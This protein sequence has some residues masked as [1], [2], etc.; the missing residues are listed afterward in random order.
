MSDR[1]SGGRPE[2]GGRPPSPSGDAGG[3]RILG[4]DLLRS[5]SA[6]W[7]VLTHGDRLI[8]PAFPRYPRFGFFNAVDAFFVLSG[9]L[10]G[11][12][13][14]RDVAEGGRT[15]GWAVL[16]QFYARRWL[17]T[18]PAYW[19]A[20]FVCWVPGRLIAGL[21]PSPD[22]RYPF[23]LQNAWTP[24]PPFFPNAWSLCIE[25]WFY[26]LF[27]AAVLLF[28]SIFRLRSRAAF[29]A[30][31]GLFIVTAMIAR[32]LVDGS[33][34]VMGATQWRG[35]FLP[36]R[37][38][39]IA[40][41]AIAALVFEAWPAAWR[42]G[43]VVGPVVAVLLV[44]LVPRLIGDGMARRALGAAIGPF[45]KSLWLPLF[46]RIHSAPG[47]IARTVRRLSRVS[48]SM[49]LVHV[50]LV[51]RPIRVLADPRAP[52]ACV[53]WYVAYFFLTAV[54]TWL[55]YR[56]AEKPGLAFRERLFPAPGARVRPAD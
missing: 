19:A 38:D 45:S 8:G 6:C 44:L 20:L 37:I 42:R 33:V 12:I 3:K 54:A 21:Y 31:A 14:L 51:L 40:Y 2:Q 56:F 52:W 36:F 25:E 47:W 55:L 24:H 17:R 5:F 50:P 28:L 11:R 53:G 48:Y 4:L 30:A 29:L 15:T 1:G 35:H 32:V 23:F 43:V 7:I 46:S 27:P 10:I 41:G 18:V 16:R 34:A 39:A 13:I 49:Y 9:F 22:W 26:L